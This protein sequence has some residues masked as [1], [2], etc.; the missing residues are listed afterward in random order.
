MPRLPDIDSLGARPTPVS[1]RGVASVQ[2]PG[3][4]GNALERAGGQLAD[5]GLRTLDRENEARDQM[6]VAKARSAFLTKKVETENAIDSDPDFDTYEPRYTEAMGKAKTEAAGL[7]RNRRARSLFEAEV[8][9][10]LA[11]G[12]GSVRSKARAR[13]VDM[14]RGALSD[15]L[16]A[17]R[18]TAL[19]AGNEADSVA[20]IETT[21]A[22]LR[23]AREAGYISAVE[24]ANWRQ[25]FSRSVLE[26]RLVGKDDAEQVELL[27]RSL[28]PEG[29]NSPFA[30]IPR[31]K[32]YALLKAAKERSRTGVAADLADSIR[33][34]RFGVV[35][36]GV[37]ADFSALSRAVELQESGGRTGLTS[38]AG[39]LGIMQVMP[40]TA[41]EISARLG[42]PYDEKK[43]RDDPA[44]GRQLG[45]EYLQQMLGRYGG[46]VTLALA[47][48]NAGPGAVDD[49]I[50]GTNRTGR[51]PSALKLG[52]PRE[53]GISADAWARA[54]PVAETRNY[55]PSVMKK[56]G[57][58]AIRGAANAPQENDL[59]RQLA[60]ADT[61]PDRETRDAVR[62]RL[63]QMDSIDAR[64]QA[65]QQRK[66]EEALWSSALEPGAADIRDLPRE[67]WM[68]ANGE[69][70]RSLAAYFAQKAKG[71][72]P[73]PNPELY[74]QLS[75]MASREP[76]KFAEAN[77]AAY[78]HLLPKGDWEQFVTLQRSVR[79]DGRKAPPS[80]THS[81]II[82]A[83]ND[84]ALAVGIDATG[85]KGAKRAE[86]VA[87]LSAFRTAVA[88]DASA[89]VAA[90]KREPTDE[91]IRK[92]ADR[93]L[94]KV[95]TRADETFGDGLSDDAKLLFEVGPDE[96]VATVII[97]PAERA[98]IVAAAKRRLGR[99]PTPEEVS[100]AYLAVKG[101]R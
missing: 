5:D 15:A 42:I 85:K 11:R 61:I 23:S 73:A 52:D 10:D 71:T 49:W 27:S 55:V 43:L 91:E 77:L 97:P 4:I 50:K 72:D 6:D 98:R 83:T 86:A 64:L 54:I 2:N 26:G 57:G 35:A 89:F 24:E 94:I 46:N 99:E 22:A 58:G 101:A 92:M 78:S 21:G 19:A 56:L 51:N 70:K 38:S 68:T 62:G 45:Q 34:G 18:E 47:A 87:R 12:I 67:A 66:A 79:T 65:D 59:N 74:I 60:I 20:V 76:E 17:S 1:R 48:Y 14:Q 90:N 63:L 31:D 44:Y 40:G 95:R 16:T 82:S 53:G 75:D 9:V 69:T 84:L 7:I 28:E 36:D 80:V 81:R 3:A 13:E 29:E 32:R 88:A 30:L 96:D 41:K 8:Q 100:S 25:D 93:H 39:A 37:Q 33:S